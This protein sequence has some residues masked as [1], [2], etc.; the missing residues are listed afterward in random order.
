MKIILEEN[1]Y[2]EGQQEVDNNT[3]GKT[4]S[5]G[6]RTV[7]QRVQLGQDT[8]SAEDSLQTTFIVEML[9]NN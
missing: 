8:E 7:Y 4:I 5:K 6:G 9:M 3:S 2:K 1:K